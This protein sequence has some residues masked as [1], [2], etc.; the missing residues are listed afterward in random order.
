MIFER[1]DEIFP[2]MKRGMSWDFE[3]KEENEV[4]LKR[5]IYSGN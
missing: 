5:V 3:R 1:I 4:Y 2:G